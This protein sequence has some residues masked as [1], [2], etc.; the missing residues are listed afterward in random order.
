[1]IIHLKTD[2]C[3]HRQTGLHDGT[4]LPRPCLSFEPT[5]CLQVPLGSKVTNNGPLP[6]DPLKEAFDQLFAWRHE[7]W[8]NIT[9]AQTQQVEGRFKQFILRGIRKLLGWE[10]ESNVEVAIMERGRRGGQWWGNDVAWSR[11]LAAEAN[12]WQ[13]A[14]QVG[15]SWLDRDE[16]VSRWAEETMIRWVESW[17]TERH[18]LVKGWTNMPT[19]Y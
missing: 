12:E 11:S 17:S 18:T 10:G 8:Q 16:L 19:C 1:M 2:L 13:S 5:Y 3:I 6:A 9:Q 7:M 14:K 4:L 15:G